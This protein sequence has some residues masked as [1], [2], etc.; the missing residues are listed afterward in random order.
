MA[1]T[2]NGM[3]LAN[4]SKA[5]TLSLRSVW[6]LRLALG[7]V[8]LLGAIVFLEGTSWDIQWHSLI[9]RDRTL[10]PPHIMMLTGVTISGLS[11]LLTILIESS[12]ARHSEIVKKNSTSFVDIFYGPLGAYIVGFAALVAAV[13]FPLDAYWHALYGIDV[14]IWAPFH[15]MFVSS[16]GIVALGA[17]YMLI[18]AGHL[19]KRA[20]NSNAGPTRAAY[21]GAIV[22]LATIL[23]IFTLLL[24]D[25]LN[26]GNQLNLGFVN[27]SVFPLLSGILIA[28]TFAA[29]AYAI[30]WRWAATSVVACYC[31]LAG[32]MALFVQPAT[33]WLL[34][35]ERL[36]YRRA[37]LPSTSL[38]ALQ[39]FLTPIIV[40]ILIDVMMYQARQKHW[41]QKKLT[42]IMAL[43][44][45]ISGAL[46]IVPGS[47]LLPAV[48]LLQVGVAGFALS[49][50]IGLGGSLLG[51][52]FGRNVGESLR[53]LEG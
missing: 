19:A 32:I 29:A 33:N 41:S 49:L 46:P 40:A 5:S 24:F 3:A 20:D 2:L 53:T 21:A 12:W 35:V 22:A 26:K 50:L 17:A 1:K 16:M 9:G 14:R 28:F 37:H 23:S 4:N 52:I 31:L 39:W 36:S 38:V 25:A 13:A 18:S 51:T 10:I 47:P 30:P 15:V 34:T 11:G 6:V 8:A 27:L 42:L 44:A 45:L 48:L 7:L 43:C